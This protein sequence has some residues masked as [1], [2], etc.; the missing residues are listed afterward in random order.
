MSARRLAAMAMLAAGGTGAAIFLAP[1][2]VS[3]AAAQVRPYVPPQQ[4]KGSDWTERIGELLPPGVETRA[5]ATE[6]IATYTP[7]PVKFPVKRTTWDGKPDFAGV[8]WPEATVTSP[9]VP[10]ES[11]YRPEARD[12]REGGGAARGLIDWRGIDT[13]GY[14]CWPASPV[15][16]S[17][18]MTLQLVSA[19]GYVMV[20]NEGLG[21]FR[22]IPIA[23]ENGQPPRRRGRPSFM[24]SSVGHWEGDT[25]VV[26]VTNFNGKPWLGPARP[27]NQL[28]Q[29]SSDALRI[30]ERWSRPDGQSL[31][32]QLVV[33]DPTMLTASW[34]GPVHRWGMVPYDT[35]LESLCFLDPDLD[36]RHREYAAQEAVRRKAAR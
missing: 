18:G 16:A 7:D 10:L 12:Y 9:S 5:E 27:P 6:R 3:R 8:Y 34:T 32:M 15:E 19:P 2:A 1:G 31:E 28:P 29:T 26:E 23:G 13:P 24:G 11:L 14:H 22:I 17:V 20:L 30:V 35:V 4:Q 33:D 36:S 21:Y 25:L